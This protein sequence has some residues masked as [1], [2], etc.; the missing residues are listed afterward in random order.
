E[1]RRELERVELEPRAHG[2]VARA[3]P[4]HTDPARGLERLVD[5]VVDAERRR[6]SELRRQPR[7]VVRQDR[8]D[9]L[10]VVGFARQTQRFAHDAAIGAAAERDVGQDVAAP[11]LGVEARRQGATPRAGGIDEGAVDVEQEDD[12]THAFSMR[13][14]ALRRG[15]YPP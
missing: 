9:E 8:I 10:R 1:T 14:L 3:E 15:K 12:W 4:D 11:D 6:R 7:D 13:R 2:D 5:A